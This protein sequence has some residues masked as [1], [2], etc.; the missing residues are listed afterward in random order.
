M[1]GLTSSSPDDRLVRECLQ[2]NNDA[3][4]ALVDKYKNLIYSIPVRLGFS[5][6]E[7][8]DIFQAVFLE[9]ISQL[10]QLREPKALPKWLMQTTSHKC[11]H[12]R[13]HRQ[14]FANDGGE[15]EIAQETSAEPGIA[16]ILQER[17][18]E[19]LLRETIG[20]LTQRCRRLIEMLFFEEPARPYTEVA[21]SLGIATGSIGFIRGRCLDKM[22]SQLEKSGFH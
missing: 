11:F 19:H 4:S 9:L 12:W 14:K 2:G 1:A 15:D 20:L 13:R 22:K 16:E 21:K 10:P 17:E 5:Q 3:W 8:T 7:A 6:D 18:Q